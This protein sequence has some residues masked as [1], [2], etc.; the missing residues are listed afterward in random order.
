MLAAFLTTLRNTEDGISLS[1]PFDDIA[2]TTGGG[3]TAGN[4]VTLTMAS[5]KTI[6][7]NFSGA[8]AIFYKLNGGTATSC[9]DGTSI[10]VAN[11]DTLQFELGSAGSENFNVLLSAGGA[12]V[13][14]WVANCS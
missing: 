7:V 12:T 2:D 8:A 9:P 6:I 3:R 14:I 11:G 4:T 1:A 13:D 5:G 10:S